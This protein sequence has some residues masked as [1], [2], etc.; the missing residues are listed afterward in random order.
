[1]DS[2]PPRLGAH[3]H[4]HL[5]GT[6]D[7][8][9]SAQ[10]HRTSLLGVHLYEVPCEIDPVRGNL[11]AAEASTLLPFIPMRYFITFHVP[12]G[13]T[14]GHHAHRSCAQFIICIHGNCRVEL[15]DGISKL[16]INLDRPTLGLL[17]P[18]MIWLVE[19]F[20]APETSVLVLASEPY[21]PMDYICDYTEFLS[22]IAKL[23]PPHELNTT[24]P[25]HHYE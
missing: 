23:A 15:D 4:T 10:I 13:Q 18:P 24:S 19:D 21:N 22:M 1:M 7:M 2:N 20:H 14:R 11:T 6:I 17:V 12:T 8:M 9:S 25:I 16:S 3:T 5:H